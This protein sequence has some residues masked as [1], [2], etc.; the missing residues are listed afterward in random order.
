MERFWL[1][2]E[3]SNIKSVAILGIGKMG[4]AMAKELAAAGF[5]VTLW[6]RNQAVADKLATEINSPNL[7]VSPTPKSAL[8]D[9][10]IAIC[11]FT[12]GLVTQSVLL[13]DSLVLEGV[14]SNL[15][16][17]DMGTSGVESAQVLARALALKKILFIDA[18][19]S[20]SVATIAAHQLLVMAS[21]DKTVIEKATPVFSVFAKKT[22]YLGEAGAGQAMKLA[23]NLIVHSLCAAVSEGLA[24]ATANGIEAATAYDVLEDSVVA[25]PFVK[26]KRSGFLEAATPVAM[27]IDTVA[28]D[29]GLILELG[30]AS[31]LPLDATTAVAQLYTHAAEAGFEAEDMAALFR[32]IQKS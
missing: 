5:Q 27:R 4:S 1:P 3:M 29:L 16:I 6:N 17:V 23:V 7:T 31:E 11:L 24:L 14:K 9:V 18:P 10:D 32:Y 13:D 19:V 2:R 12:N 30:K 8:A 25:A 26:Y 22:A 28:K 21:G 15:I 20:G